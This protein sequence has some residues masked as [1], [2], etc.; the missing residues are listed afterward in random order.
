MVWLVHVAFIISTERLLLQLFTLGKL[1]SDLSEKSHPC[2]RQARSGICIWTEKLART[3]V[4]SNV[5]TSEVGEKNNWP[6]SF[7]QSP[8]QLQASRCRH[9]WI[10]RIATIQSIQCKRSVGS[11]AIP[12]NVAPVYAN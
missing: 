8:Q 5:Y 1:V 2:L 10:Y 9:F 7:S 6:A 3:R 4:Y 12:V 11:H